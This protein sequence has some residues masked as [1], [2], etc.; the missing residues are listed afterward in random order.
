MALDSF[1]ECGDF[2]MFEESNVKDLSIHITENKTHIRN[3]E[4]L[5]KKTE[6][7]NIG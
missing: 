5:N 6:K 7:K 2:R 4:E 1:E 3:K